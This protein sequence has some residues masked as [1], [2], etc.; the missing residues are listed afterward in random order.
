MGG[1]GFLQNVRAETVVSGH[2]AIPPAKE[3]L[4]SSGRF[5]FGRELESDPAIPHA[6]PQFWTGSPPAQE[7]R[8]KAGRQ[9][10]L[11]LAFRAIRVRQLLS[12][13]G[14]YGAAVR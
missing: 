12:I 6:A 7:K 9:G 11:V 10:K 2:R 13:C 4:E 5:M 14:V 8:V 1:P 3:G